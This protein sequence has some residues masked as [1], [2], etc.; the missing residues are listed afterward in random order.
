M[1]D[2]QFV[3]CF[4]SFRIKFDKL[5]QRNVYHTNTHKNT[6]TVKMFIWIDITIPINYLHMIYN[7]IETLHAI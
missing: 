2:M 4:Q 6:D 5:F 7:Q 1:Y 3:F